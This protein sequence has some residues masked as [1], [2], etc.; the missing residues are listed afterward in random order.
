MS[1][2]L[3]AQARELKR[4]QQFNDFPVAF[5]VKELL[6]G[7]GQSV[8]GESRPS[9]RSARASCATA[10]SSSVEKIARRSAKGTPGAPGLRAT[11]I[12]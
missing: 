2:I 8:P 9:T 5:A 12:T 4:L 6:V 3:E 7:T 10:R 11:A 1:R